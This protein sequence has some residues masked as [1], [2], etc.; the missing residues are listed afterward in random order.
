MFTLSQSVPEL[1][2]LMM[3]LVISGLIFASLTYYI[4]MVSGAQPNTVTACPNC[5]RTTLD[6]LTSPPPS[7]G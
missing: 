1:G 6:S 3:I 4:E 2:L 7:T 5:R